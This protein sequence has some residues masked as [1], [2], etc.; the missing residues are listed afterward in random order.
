MHTIYKD[1]LINHIIE[2]ISNKKNLSLA[3]YDKITYEPD[4]EFWTIEN[5]KLVV[6]PIQII[7]DTNIRKSLKT[8]LKGLGLSDNEINILGV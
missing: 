3:K 5:E 6:K 8:K 4:R 7:D 2:D 1:K